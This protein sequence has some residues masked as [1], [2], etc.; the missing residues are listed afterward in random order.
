M[1]VDQNAGD[2]NSV[3]AENSSYNWIYAVA[4][5]IEHHYGATPDDWKPNLDT[6]F[7]PVTVQKPKQTIERKIFQKIF[8]G[9]NLGNSIRFKYDANYFKYCD[10]VGSISDFYYALYNVFISIAMIRDVP[11]NNKH[12]KNISIYH[13]TKNIL[14]YP[15]NI[16]SEFDPT[17]WNGKNLINKNNFKCVLPELL[18]TTNNSFGYINGTYSGTLLD[19]TYSQDIVHG[20]L[21]GTL[22]YYIGAQR[23]ELEATLKRP[24]NGR[25]QSDKDLLNQKLIK[26]KINFMNCLYRYR[27]KAHY[28]D[29]SFLTYKYVDADKKTNNT[30]NIEFYDFMARIIEFATC[31]TIIH[32][33]QR[34]GKTTVKAYLDDFTNKFKDQIPTGSDYWNRLI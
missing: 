11:E 27:T 17:T 3:Y 18:S 19:K 2:P 12:G 21:I 10:L 4:S 25:L 22:E 28:R 23:E 24:L 6:H 8:H 1:L 9:I 31:A 13:N 15:F 16:V 7:S 29:F 5:E 20:Y 30:M 34:I 32:A 33:K 26:L 14:P